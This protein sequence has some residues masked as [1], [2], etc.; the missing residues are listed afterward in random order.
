MG[1]E[2]EICDIAV[3]DEIMSCGRCAQNYKKN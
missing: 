1:T 2:A 3:F